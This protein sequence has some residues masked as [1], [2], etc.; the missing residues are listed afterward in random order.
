MLTGIVGLII[1]G[2]SKLIDSKNKKNVFDGYVQARDTVYNSLAS[3]AATPSAI[4]ASIS[5]NGNKLKN[6]LTNTGTCSATQPSSAVA[7]DLYVPYSRKDDKVLVSGGSDGARYN[8]KGLRTACQPGKKCFF[9]AQTYFYAECANKLPTCKIAKSINVI[10]RVQVFTAARKSLGV[11]GDSGLADRPNKKRWNRNKGDGALNIAV[12]AIMDSPLLCPTNKVLIGIAKNQAVCKCALGFKLDPKTN[13]CL[14]SKKC[15]KKTYFIG[16][17]NNGEPLCE[18]VPVLNYICKNIKTPSTGKAACPS[19]Y[20]MR[21]A[22]VSG[23]CTVKKGSN[24]VECP[25]MRLTCCKA[26]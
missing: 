25:D 23:E 3:Q 7:F 5:K 8:H 17:Q 10:P 12:S 9:Y 6:C 20:K 4:R 14:A 22:Q 11:K 16:I 15:P 2:S 13:K 24:L 26:R 1:A 19:G 21:A 18:P